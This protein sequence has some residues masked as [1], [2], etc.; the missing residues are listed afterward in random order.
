MSFSGFNVQV[1][2]QKVIIK[3][4][5]FALSDHVSLC[6]CVEQLTYNGWYLHESTIQSHCKTF[7]VSLN[8]FKYVCSSINTSL[9]RD[10]SSIGVK[11]RKMTT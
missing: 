6:N 10:H 11:L 5:T 8:D 2:M 4:S 9:A 3:I 1:V 7:F